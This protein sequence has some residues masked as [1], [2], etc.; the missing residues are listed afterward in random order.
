MKLKTCGYTHST[1][2]NVIWPYRRAKCVV[3]LILSWWFDLRTHKKF[4]MTKIVALTVVCTTHFWPS[5]Q[6]FIQRTTCTY[7][8]SSKCLEFIESKLTKHCEQ[9]G[10]CGKILTNYV[11]VSL[12]LWINS[13]SLDSGRRLL[14]RWF[15]VVL[16]PQSTEIIAQWSKGE[17]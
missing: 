8:V 4:G 17:E 12:L 15:H 9:N 6:S 3:T 10:E 7:F 2:F 1:F 13:S 16:I 5:T 11:G 14:N